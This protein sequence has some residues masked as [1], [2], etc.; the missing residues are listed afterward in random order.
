MNNRNKP[1]LILFGKSPRK[2]PRAA[3][4]AAQDAAVARWVAERQRLT[5][6]K[7]TPRV[8]Q[9][10]GDTLLEWQ[11]GPQGQ[12]IVPDISIHTFDR[13]TAL[14]A[15]SVAAGEAYETAAEAEPPAP[16]SPEQRDAAKLLWGA[17]AVGSTVLAQDAGPEDG[18]WAAQVLAKHRTS[19]VL[20]FPGFPEEGLVVRELHQLAMLP[21]NGRA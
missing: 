4:F 6:L 10:P 15:Q 2:P 16:L 18:W 1:A 19:C 5:F 17:L 9:E 8:L 13:L 12:P 20:C 11:L 7:A 21:V 14:A 3:W